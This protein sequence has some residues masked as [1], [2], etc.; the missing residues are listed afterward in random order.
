MK[1]IVLETNLMPDDSYYELE[2]YNNFEDETLISICHMDKRGQ[3]IQNKTL[4]IREI[5]DRIE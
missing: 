1:K 4:R 5:L 3:S 2:I